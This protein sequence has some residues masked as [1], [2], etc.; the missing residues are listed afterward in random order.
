LKGQCGE[1]II[2]PEDGHYPVSDTAISLPFEADFAR[3][4]SAENVNSTAFADSTPNIFDRR[5]N[6]V[7]INFIIY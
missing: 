5:E 6:H 1:T 2:S 7:Y 4:T 3:V